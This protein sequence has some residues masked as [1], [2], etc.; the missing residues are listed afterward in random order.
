[1]FIF[2]KKKNL[3]S[4]VSEIQRENTFLKRDLK[5]AVERVDKCEGAIL[6]RMVTYRGPWEEAQ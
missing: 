2:R 1:M 5:T 3:L 4:I 6:I